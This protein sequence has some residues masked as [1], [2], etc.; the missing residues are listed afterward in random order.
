MK[1]KRPEAPVRLQTTSKEVLEGLLALVQRKF[2]AGEAVQFAKDR[3]HLLQWALLWPARHW[4]K[5]KEVALPEARY[6]EILSKVIIEAAAF[7]TGPIRYRPAWL[8]EVIQ[9]H[10]RIHGEEIY[11]EAKA[12]RTLAEHTLLQLGKLPTRPQDA[13]VNEFDAASRLLDRPKAK[14]TVAKPVAKEQLNLL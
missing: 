6:Q 8:G 12:M 7:Q 11:A 4:F 1:P 10:F 2:Y 3:R 14:K 5:E 9:S 13:L